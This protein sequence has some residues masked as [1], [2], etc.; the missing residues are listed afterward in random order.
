MKNYTDK[1]LKYFETEMLKYRLP[2]ISKQWKKYGVPFIRYTFLP[3]ILIIAIFGIIYSNSGI[4]RNE[5]MWVFDK[6]IALSYIIGFGSFTLIAHVSELYGANKLRKR[7]KLN[8]EDF[9]TLVN[10]FQI[11]GMK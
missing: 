7:L 4:G 2:W 10:V 11:T 3:A 8:R 1:E 6:A 5:W 9:N